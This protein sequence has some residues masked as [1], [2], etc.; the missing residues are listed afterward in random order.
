M[1]KIVKFKDGKFAVRN[2]NSLTGYGY[3][4]IK[5]SSGYWWAGVGY[6]EYFKV[7][8]KE[9]AIKMYNRVTD[10]GVPIH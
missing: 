4:D 1:I 5:P 6:G 8:T 9:E 10:K 2:G 7:D 3:L